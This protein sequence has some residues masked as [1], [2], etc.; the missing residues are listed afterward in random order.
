[1]LSFYKGLCLLF[2]AQPLRHFL[3]KV[4]QAVRELILGM[5]WVNKH[6]KHMFAKKSCAFFLL[7]T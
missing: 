7:Q 6:V 3:F 2:T 4:A 5:W 1:M